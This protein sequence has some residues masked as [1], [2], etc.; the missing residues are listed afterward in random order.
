M[1]LWTTSTARCTAAPSV[2]QRIDGPDLP[3][4]PSQTSGTGQTLVSAI[5]L[6]KSPCTFKYYMS[7]LP[8]IKNPYI[9]VLSFMFRPLI[10]LV[11]LFSSPPL[12]FYM[13]D[14]FFLHIITFRSLIS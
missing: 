6:H 2:H 12:I 9:W 5:I 11:F 3:K 1:D 4:P 8:P 7:V 10:S 13:L 14:L